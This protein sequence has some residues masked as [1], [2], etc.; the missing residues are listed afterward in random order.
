MS[1][2]AA[3]RRVAAVRAARIR[4]ISFVVVSVF[5]ILRDSS[6]GA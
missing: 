5:I 4:R 3:L 2:N 6:A 1:G